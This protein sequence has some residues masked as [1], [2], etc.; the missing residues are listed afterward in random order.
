MTCPVHPARSLSPAIAPNSV[1]CSLAGRQHQVHG[2]Y[3]GI[4][5]HSNVQRCRARLGRKTDFASNCVEVVLVYDAVAQHVTEKPV[6]MVPES[7]AAGQL[8]VQL[9]VAIR[10]CRRRAPPEARGAESSSIAWSITVAVTPA[11][12]T[13]TPLCAVELPSPLRSYL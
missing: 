9:V 6:E 3:S 8:H 12:D 4:S 7:C 10:R 11:S 13:G 2:C 5:A 1:W